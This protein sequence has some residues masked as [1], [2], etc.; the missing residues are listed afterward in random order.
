[1]RPF[2]WATLSLLVGILVAVAA[3]VTV[4]P[5]PAPPS[6]GMAFGRYGVSVLVKEADDSVRFQVSFQT[7]GKVPDRVQL[8]FPG[9]TVSN[10]SAREAF[11]HELAV[12]ASGDTVDAVMALPF[13]NLGAGGIVT[14]SF[15]ERFAHATYGWGARWTEVPWAEHFGLGELRDV[16][17]DA[18]WMAV[19]T[20]MP[21]DYPH[22]SGFTCA[23]TYALECSRITLSATAPLRLPIAL[24]DDREG[25]AVLA[26]AVLAGL[27]A[28]AAGTR[29]AVRRLR[30]SHGTP[31][32][33]PPA[34]PDA[35]AAVGYRDA[36]APL[37]PPPRVLP[38]E[39]RRRLAARALFVALG[40][41]ASTVAIA[42]LADQRAPVPMPIAVGLWALVACIV[43]GA[44]IAWRGV[45]MLAPLAIGLAFAAPFALP[46][47]G[48]AVATALAPAGL[49]GIVTLAMSAV[50][51]QGL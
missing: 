38:R 44:S 1:M 7:D 45:R 12:T 17:S 40:C 16:T 21:S 25:Y 14:V 11:G 36:P 22:P 6:N 37:A 30:A 10:V 27:S 26:L 3:A 41:A 19:T 24:H 51:V 49:A 47:L 4:R 33:R 23:E 5:P 39:V 20:S 28:L 2:V 29:L 35:D 46:S 15:D 31:I 8:S 32:A 43:G 9:G 50:R 42:V 48:V 34:A 13:R 18:A